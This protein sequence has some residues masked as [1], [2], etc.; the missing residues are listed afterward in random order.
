MGLPSPCEHEPTRFS[1]ANFKNIKNNNSRKYVINKIVSGRLRCDDQLGWIL[2]VWIKCF[3]FFIK[4]RKF[5]TLVN[6]VL[7]SEIN[8]CN[9]GTFSNKCKSSLSKPV[10]TSALLITNIWITQKKLILIYRYRGIYLLKFINNIYDI[11]VTKR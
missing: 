6:F 5:Q 7:R 11:K 1:Y 3:F 8:F 4:T 10:E 2:E 9:T